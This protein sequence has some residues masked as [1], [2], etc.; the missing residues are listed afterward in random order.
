MYY[1]NLDDN[2][3]HQEIQCLREAKH[4]NIVRCLGYCFG[5][6]GEMILYNGKFVMAEV[7]HRLLCFEYLSKG[8]LSNYITGR[9][10]IFDNNII[11]EA[12][13]TYNLNHEFTISYM[14]YHL[15]INEVSV[16]TTK[17]PLHVPRTDGSSGL[18]WR[19]RY[20]IIKGICQGLHYLHAKHIVH[21]DLNP[22][23]ILLDDNMVPKIAGFGISRC[24]GK[25]ETIYTETLRG[26]P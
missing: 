7:P 16:S 2:N 5:S 3:F 1:S 9:G 8:S 17:R 22:T 25:H 4:K 12:S 26:T 18:E 20:Q 15:N 21:L 6:H 10:M 23:N 24:F 13:H 14:T 11:C 19:M